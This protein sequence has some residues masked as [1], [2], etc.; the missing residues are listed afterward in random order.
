M[1]RAPQPKMDGLR[2]SNFFQII[3]ANYLPGLNLSQ[4]AGLDQLSYICLQVSLNCGNITARLLLPGL[5][6]GYELGQLSQIGWGEA[7]KSF[8]DGTLFILV[9][10]P[11]LLSFPN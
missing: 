4:P 7:A 10:K 6:R 5:S 3:I 2:S 1:N 9:P 8:D 11:V